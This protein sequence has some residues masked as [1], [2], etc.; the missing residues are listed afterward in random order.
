MDASM[1][2]KDKA[3]ML[4]RLRD[5]TLVIQHPERDRIADE[6]ERL[7]DALQRSHK[8]LMQYAWYDQ[9]LTGLRERNENA[10]SGDLK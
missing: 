9:G 7:R 2:A 6:I 1:I 4:A 8:E 10:L 3:E 5:K